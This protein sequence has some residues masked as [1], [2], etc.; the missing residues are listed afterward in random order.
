MV[1][2][3]AK[4]STTCEIPSEIKGAFHLSELNVQPIP[5]VMMIS[6]SIKTNHPYQSNP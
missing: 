6:L 1:A 4:I 2:H 5:I 3:E